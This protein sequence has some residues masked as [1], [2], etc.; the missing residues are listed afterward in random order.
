MD[1]P[2]THSHQLACIAAEPTL[3]IIDGRGEIGAKR[4]EYETR[5]LA[6]GLARLGVGCRSRVAILCRNHR[7]FVQASRA[8]SLLGGSAHYMGT[9]WT[10]DD[11]R[12]AATTAGSEYVIYD[13]DLAELSE[14]VA[15]RDRSI[16]AWPERDGVAR[17]PSVDGLIASSEPMA[18]EPTGTHVLFTSGTTGAPTPVGRRGTSSAEALEGLLGML[19]LR[20]GATTVVAAPLYH[21]WGLLQLRLGRRRSS[22][23]ALPRHFGNALEIVGMLDRHAPDALVTIP[24]VLRGLSD[25]ARRTG[26][27]WDLSLVVVAG[28][29]LPPGLAHAARAAFGE[30][31]HAVYGTTEAGWISVATPAD[32]HAD[33]AIAGRPVAGT[34][35]SILDTDGRPVEP[36]VK[37]RIC[38]CTESGGDGGVR[39][40]GPRRRDVDTGD[41]GHLD[42]EGRLLIDGRGD[43][44]IVTGGENVQPAEVERAIASLPGV[45]D[46]AVAGIGDERYSAVLHAFVVPERPQDFRPQELRRVLMRVLAPYKV[47]RVVHAVDSLPR[48][49]TGKVLRRA[50]VD[51][52]ERQGRVLA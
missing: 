40:Y 2:F 12:G 3:A 51:E 45:A 41:L 34:T 30:T 31:L 22:I 49:A 38:V 33:P 4:L 42:N 43:D 37:G 18:G 6:G 48:T 24:A 20:D 8:V 7:M 1:H 39:A 52:V 27:R 25:L 28:S 32:I 16:L 17:E 35:I 36:G 29:A 10:A 44:L 9:S 26:R 13:A 15:P 46:V 50:L 23:L 5:K 14:G 21:A 47:P 11:V 19:P